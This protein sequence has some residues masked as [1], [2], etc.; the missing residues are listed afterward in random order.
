[1]FIVLFEHQPKFAQ[2]RAT[3]QTITFH[4]GKTQVNKKPFVATPRLTKKCFFFFFQLL[5]FESKNMD[6][7]Q[8]AQLKIRKKSKG[9]KK[10]FEREIRTE[11]QR[12]EKGLM[13][14]NFVI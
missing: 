11:N 4:I 2:K 10:G 14:T 3:K 12:K 6:V 1:M 7:E 13:K 9:K 5:L 8:E